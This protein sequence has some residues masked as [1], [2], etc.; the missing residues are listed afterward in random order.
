MTSQATYWLVQS[1]LIRSFIIENFKA[2]LQR[3]FTFFLINIVLFDAFQHNFHN[4]IASSHRRKYSKIELRNEMS[5]IHFQ[6]FFPQTSPFHVPLMQFYEKKTSNLSLLK[7]FWGATT[8]FSEMQYK[9]TVWKF[10]CIIFI[11]ITCSFQKQIFFIRIR[12]NIKF[13]L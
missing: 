11:Y 6:T 10:E 1:C 8:T 12:H 13:V 2:S 9:C 7:T 4:I 3:E 5:K